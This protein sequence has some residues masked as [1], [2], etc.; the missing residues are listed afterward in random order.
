MSCLN[1]YTLEYSIKSSIKILYD[2]ISTPESLA[3]WFSDEV[4][5]KDDIITF[6]WV[7]QEQKARLLNKKEHEWV[8]YQWLDEHEH[9]SQ[10]LEMKIN[11]EPITNDISLTITDFCKAEDLTEQKFLWDMSINNLVKRIGGQ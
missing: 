3:E 11:I 2:F 4:K 7:D 1:K 8:R 9:P 5:I 10:Y 6:K